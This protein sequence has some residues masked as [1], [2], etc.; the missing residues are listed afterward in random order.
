MGSA[1]P[2]PTNSS[3][4]MD[5]RVESPWQDL[6]F[7]CNAIFVACQVISLAVQRLEF[8]QALQGGIKCLGLD[9]SATS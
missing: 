9:K 4:H 8:R 6:W 3:P 5:P 7:Y 2:T 1:E